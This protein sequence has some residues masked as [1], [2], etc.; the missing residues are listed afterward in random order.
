MLPFTFQ[1]FI[2]NAAMCLAVP[3][4]I[5][6]VLGTTWDRFF[7]TEPTQDDYVPR[8]AAKMILGSLTRLKENWEQAET[9]ASIAASA[10]QAYAQLIGAAEKR[11]AT[12]MDDP[13][14]TTA[15]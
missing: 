9:E 11:R 6:T 13:M 2:D 4:F 14:S 10:Q 8:Q 12:L 5:R 3:L 7:V 15:A 1:D